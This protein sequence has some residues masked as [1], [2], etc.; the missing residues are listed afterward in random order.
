MVKS[1]ER[2]MRECDRNTHDHFCLSMSREQVRV[3]ESRESA[4]E[5]W[6]LRQGRRHG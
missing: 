4:L 1:Y 6:K 2:K 3:V 5:A